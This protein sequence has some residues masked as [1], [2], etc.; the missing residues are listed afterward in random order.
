MATCQ[1]C[2][3]DGWTVEPVCCGRT[4]PCCGQPDPEQVQCAVCAGTG[5]TEDEMRFVTCTD[6][7]GDG[8][9]DT[10]QGSPYSSNWIK[11][12]ACDGRGEV[13][14]RVEP[15][16]LEDIEFH[17]LALTDPHLYNQFI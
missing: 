8:G 7:G 9:G 2:N 3:G 10:D 5:Q 4:T 15:I 14:V 13:A 6:C 12:R 17:D 1:R 16:T 11:C